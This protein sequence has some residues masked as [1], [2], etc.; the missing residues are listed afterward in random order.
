MAREVSSRD[1]V[2]FALCG[3]IIPDHPIISQKYPII[4]KVKINMSLM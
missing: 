2:C 3:K 4:K 1:A